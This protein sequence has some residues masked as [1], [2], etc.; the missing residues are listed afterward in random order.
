VEDGHAGFAA[1][2]LVHHAQGGPSP[3]GKSLLIEAATAEEGM[4]RFAIPLTDIQ[5]FVAFLLVS[6]GKIS[7]MQ[8]LEASSPDIAAPGTLP[9]PVTSIAIGEPA[10]SEGYLGI[11]VG[12]AELIFAVPMS[13][14]DPL[15]RTMLT[16]SAQPNP[17][18]K[19]CAA[20]RAGPGEAG[21]SGRRFFR[22]H[23]S[24]DRAKLATR[25]RPRVRFDRAIEIDDPFADSREGRSSPTAAA[26]LGR[27]R[28]LQQGAVDFLDQQPRPAVR[29]LE[30]P[31]RGG[32]RSGRS[33][34]LQQRDLARSDAVPACQVDADGK[35][36]RGHGPRLPRRIPVASQADGWAL[37]K[38]HVSASAALRL[39]A[40]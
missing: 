18:Y 29:H 30:R 27:D 31:R 23:E 19:T 35:A 11:A 34:R 8:G 33:D 17:Q 25:R 38:E 21:N 2:P 10:G 37:V 39:D 12:Q 20:A 32:D 13:A 5:H 40:G 22:A 3:D 15:G 4:L 14:F 24:S 26:D 9:I 6:V 36:C 16:V 7:A 28:W 1:F